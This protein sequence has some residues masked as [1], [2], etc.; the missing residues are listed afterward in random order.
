MFRQTPRDGGPKRKT[1][2]LA[3]WYEWLFGPPL[4]DSVRAGNA[5]EVRRYAT[6]RNVN[7]LVSRG[8][9]YI[10]QSLLSLAAGAGHLEVLQAL[11]DKGASINLSNNSGLTALSEALYNGHVD[12]A[13]ELIR[14]GADV[15]HV[16]KY[17]E[18]YL[19]D[20]A[21]SGDLELLKLLVDLDLDPNALNKVWTAHTVW[22]KD[23]A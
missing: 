20:A 11:L 18:T 19:H 5:A 9:G 4:A 2:G 23:A 1:G 10:P 22:R 15:T 3:G 14:R 8:S 21:A 17:G 13:T 12:C 7:A 6:R 16:S